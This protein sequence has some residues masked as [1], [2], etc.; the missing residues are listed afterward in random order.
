MKVLWI[1]SFR[2]FKKKSRDTSIQM[3]FLKEISRNKNI[4]FCVTQ[5]GETNVKEQLQKNVKKFYFY[6]YGKNKN[7]KY[8]QNKILF[9]GLNTAKKGKYD[10]FIWSTAD[11]ILTKNYFSKFKKIKQNTI[12]TIFPNIHIYKKKFDKTKPNFGLDIFIFNL[13]KLKILKLIKLNNQCPNYDWG[14]YEHFLFSIHKVL[15]VKI[16]N[17]NGYVNIFKFDNQ[18]NESTDIQLSQIKSWK[19]NNNYLKKFL[20]KYKQSMLYASG[21]FYF[22]AFKLI[23]RTP[24]TLDNL[25]IY[26]RLFYK[27]L[28]TIIK[29]IRF[30]KSKKF[31]K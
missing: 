3:K 27:L 13:E 12:A 6:D 8:C 4:D 25:I 5:F 10:L 7:Y 15:K 11:I 21:S 23:G 22:I 28:L 29:K 30:N 24:L 18:E 9:N 14:S 1:T 19:K 31:D 20:R 2:S 17:L 26:G 16:V